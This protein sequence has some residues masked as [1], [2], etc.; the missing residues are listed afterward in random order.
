MTLPFIGQ[1]AT[2]ALNAGHGL[3]A[4]LAG[5]MQVR[6]SKSDEALEQAKLALQG[7]TVE[8]AGLTAAALQNYRNQ[9]LG[10]TKRG[11]DITNENSD[12]TRALTSELGHGNLQA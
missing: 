10:L 6:K 11:Q 1:P 8:N 9:S 4:F 7:K 12:A 3:N 2:P 5:L